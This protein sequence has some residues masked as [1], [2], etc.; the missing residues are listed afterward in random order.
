[1]SSKFYMGVHLELSEQE[2]IEIQP[3][4]YIVSR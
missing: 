3:Y 1:M 2:S 4:K